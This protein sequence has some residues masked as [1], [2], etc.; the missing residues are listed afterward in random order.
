MSSSKF[1]IEEKNKI[2]KFVN[3]SPNS[4]YLLDSLKRGAKAAELCRDSGS[5][6]SHR[7][8]DCI[9][10]AMENRHLFEYMQKIGYFCQLPF[11]P[12]RTEIEC[13]RIELVTGL[14][15]NPKT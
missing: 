14:P 7:K 4:M 15:L 6:G 1:P 11:D 2:D 8:A 12:S 13:R 10:L 3:Q 9:S 5:S